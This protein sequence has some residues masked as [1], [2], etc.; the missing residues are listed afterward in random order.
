MIYKTL[1]RK[2][3]IE[4]YEPPLKSR[5]EFSCPWR[6]KTIPAPLVAPTVTVKFMLLLRMPVKK[7]LHRDLLFFSRADNY[8]YKVNQYIP[9]I[10]WQCFLIVYSLRCLVYTWI[11]IIEQR[12]CCRFIN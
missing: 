6:V 8:F 9:E 5:G 4:Q 3:K 1:L 12:D 7:E 2:L 10:E 11:R